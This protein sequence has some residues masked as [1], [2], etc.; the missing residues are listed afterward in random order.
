M[1]YTTDA[2]MGPFLQKWK[3]L[4]KEVQDYTSVP[5]DDLLVML[6]DKLPQG[7]WELKAEQVKW[8]KDRRKLDWSPQQSYDE[9]IDMMD[10]HC[11]YVKDIKI[12]QS[13]RIGYDNHFQRTYGQHASQTT[14]VGG[15]EQ[16]DA[17]SYDG[18]KRGRGNRGKGKGY[19]SDSSSTKGKGRGDKG[20]VLACKRCGKPGHVVKDCTLARGN[21]Y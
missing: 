5:I 18:S 14:Q 17:N 16:F 21:N 8:D 9:L 1:G 15:V 2:E 20:N 3:Q 4:S 10:T 6:R 11:K 19:E 12:E 7:D 13:A